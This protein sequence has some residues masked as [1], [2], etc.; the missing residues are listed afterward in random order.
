MGE[1][2]KVQESGSIGLSLSRNDTEG[3]AR[4]FPGHVQQ[5]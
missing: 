1:G 5:S 4:P 3:P 2:E